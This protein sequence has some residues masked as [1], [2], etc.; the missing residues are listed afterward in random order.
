MGKKINSVIFVLL[1]VLSFKTVA[2]SDLPPR[3]IVD[4]IVAAV[5]DHIIL[6]SEFESE[7]TQIEQSG[8][9]ATPEIRCYVLEEL[10]QRKLLV[11][12]AEIDSL[13]VSDEQ[14][15]DE[16]DRRI[17]YFAVQVGGEK[18]LEQYLQKSIREYKKEM[19]PK[20]KQQMLAAEMERK[21][22]A[23]IKVTPNEVRSFFERIPRDSLPLIGAEIELSQIILK[24][25]PSQFARDYAYGELEKIRRDIVERGADFTMMAKLHSDD[26]GTKVRGGSLGEF[27][28]GDMV[29]EFERAVFKLEKNGVSPIIE[30]QFGFH[31]I[32]LVERR[33]ERVEARHI[34]L[35]PKASSY[36]VRATESLADSLRRVFVQNKESYCDL[37]KNFTEDEMTKGNCGYL[38]DPQTGITKLPAEYMDEQTLKQIRGLSPGE[39]SEPV[40]IEM[41]DGSKVVRLVFLKTEHPPHIVNLVDDYTRIQ[42]LALENKREEVMQKWVAKKVKDTY[43]MVDNS[44][45]SCDFTYTWNEYKTKQ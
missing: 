32:Q 44:Y 26:P 20:M 24:P 41:P 17:K 43:F 27:G 30:T 1:M 23:D 28:R 18:K 14:I 36:E 39:M 29:P 25:K 2:Q 6:R 21:I 34:L 15:D 33:G 40:T 35:R 45:F 5:G 3:Q 11:H 4:M 12:Q 16:L 38:S 10:M 37:V 13:P 7:L 22:Y 19:R 9:I 42:M 31:I 8:E